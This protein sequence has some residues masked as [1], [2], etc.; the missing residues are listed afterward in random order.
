MATWKELV[1]VSSTQTLTNKT[2]TTAE[3]GSSTATTQS[4]SDNSTKVATTAY[5]DNQSAQGDKTLTDKHIWIGGSTGEKAEQSI[6]GAITM[7]RDGTTTLVNDAVTYG[8]IQNI[9]TANRVL[10]SSS[11]N[12]IVAEVQVATAMIADNAITNA[13]IGDDQI[14][15]EHYVD[16]SIDTAHIADNAVDGSKLADNIDV[17][18]TLDVTSTATFDN[19]VTIAGTLTV[20]G[21]T[22][23]VATTNLEVKDKNILLNKATHT[24]DA[25]AVNTADG[26]GISIQ[27]DSGNDSSSIANYA[28]L[29]WNKS[30]ALTGWQVEDTANAGSFPIAIMEHSSNSTAPTGN[31]GGVGSFHFDSGDDKLYVRTA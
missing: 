31:A 9:A 1:D 20:N 29:T 28:N 12:S 11:S 8:K 19:N 23:S 5:V 2:L 10:G 7:G 26:A 22:T 18:G 21:T 16:G 15:S 14:D 27:T 30:G 24:D 13:L 17:A 3:L 25:G 4:A 6:S